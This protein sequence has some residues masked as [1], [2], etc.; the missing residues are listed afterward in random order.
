MSAATTAAAADPRDGLLTFA[1][2]HAARG[3]RVFPLAPGGKRPAVK[4]WEHRATTD[5][6]RIERAWT[7][8][9]F[10]IGL[11]CGPSGLVVIDLDQPKPGQLAPQAYRQSGVREGGDVLAMLCE[12]NDQPLPADTYS[13][14]TAS[15][16]QH[17]YFAAPAGAELRNTAGRLGWLIDTRA[18]GGYVVAAGSTITGRPYTALVPDTD[19]APLPEWLT[20]RLGEP[21]PA[22]AP[23]TAG[24]LGVASPGAYA[25][26]ALRGELDRVL[27]APAGQRNHTLNTAAFALGQ[28][29]AAGLLARQLAEDALTLAGQ[30]IGLSAR[31]CAATIR[32]GLNSGERAPRHPAA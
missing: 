27:A 12:A 22:T 24:E 30:G 31:E 9:A 1:L 20:V 29:T 17:L 15:G 5:P 3:W 25:A 11:A 2:G 21:D 10:N 32:S 23:T 7:V 4:D 13:V 18:R 6:A 26:S 28:L 14:R 19:P 8:G 16:G